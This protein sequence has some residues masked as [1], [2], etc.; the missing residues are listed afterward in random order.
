MV[1]EV[2][3]RFGQQRTPKNTPVHGWSDLSGTPPSSHGVSGYRKNP[4]KQGQH[5]QHGLLTIYH[6]IY[7]V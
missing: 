4:S 5:K 3:V 7:V 2:D 1:L 6:F